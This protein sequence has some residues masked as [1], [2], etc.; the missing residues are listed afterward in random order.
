M[1]ASQVGP[2]RARYRYQVGT[3][4]VHDELHRQ[5]ASVSGFDV[6]ATNYVRGTA[7]LLSWKKRFCCRVHDVEELFLL[8]DWKFI[9]RG[10]L[11]RMK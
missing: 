3:L 11:Q 5:A 7:D 4:K 6:D 1:T 9:S 8:P 2:G 10:S